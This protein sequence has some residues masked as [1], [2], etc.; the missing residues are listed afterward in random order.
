MPE[1]YEKPEILTQKMELNVLRAD[2]Q[3]KQN[4][5]AGSISIDWG[6]YID[7]SCGSDCTI[8]DSNQQTHS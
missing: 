7:Q 4:N 5:V 1:K 2:C 8:T 3:N 6:C